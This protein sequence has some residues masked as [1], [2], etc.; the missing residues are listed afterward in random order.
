MISVKPTT[1]IVRFVR[2][3]EADKGFVEQPVML[4]D[5]KTGWTISVTTRHEGSREVAELI[6]IVFEP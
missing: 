1:K 2:S 6:K 5:L 3:A 4:N